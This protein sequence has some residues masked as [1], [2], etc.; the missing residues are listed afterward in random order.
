[1]VGNRGDS[2]AALHRDDRAERRRR[3]GRY[4]SV[5]AAK[6]KSSCEARESP[7]P[8]VAELLVGKSGGCSIVDGYRS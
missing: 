6:Q 4:L 7:A 8:R 1:L 2:A 3:L 5:G